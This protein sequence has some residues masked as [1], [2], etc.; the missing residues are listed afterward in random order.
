MQVYFLKLKQL[1]ISFTSIKAREVSLVAA[2]CIFALL[3][4]LH[5]PLV[6]IHAGLDPSFNYGIGKA[7]LRNESFGSDFIATYGPLGYLIIDYLPNF[8]IQASLLL[9]FFALAL[10]LGSYLFVRAWGPKYW[11]A[12]LGLGLGVIY[13]FSLSYGIEWNLLT[14]FLLY[15]FL[16]AYS[17]RRS[18]ALLAVLSL[19]AATFLFIKLTLGLAAL[20]SAMLLPVSSAVLARSAR[21]RTLLAE[22]FTVAL[23]YVVGVLVWSRLLHV[24]NLIMYARTGWEMSTGFSEAMSYQLPGTFVATVFCAIALLALVTVYVVDFSR[25]KIE[26]RAVFIIPALYMIWKYAVVRQDYHILRL[27]QII[28]PL[29]MIIIVYRLHKTKT[30]AKVITLAMASLVV[31]LTIYTVPLNRLDLAKDFLPVLKIPLVNIQNGS[32]LHFFEVGSEEQAWQKAS[33]TNVASDKLPDKFVKRIGASGVDIYPWE[34][35]IVAANNLT[36]QNRPSPYSFETYRPLF[37]NLNAAYFESARAPKYV[38]WHNEGGV[39]GVDARN[40]VWDEPKTLRTMLQFYSPVES[41]DQ[42]ILLQRNKHAVQRSAS[43]L[44]RQIVDWGEWVDVPTPTQQKL[45]FFTASYA[46]GKTIAIEDVLLRSESVSVSLEYKDES[47]VTY[48]VVPKMLVQGY[49]ASDVPM[50]WDEL[51]KLLSGQYSHSVQRIRFNAN[52][53]Y[54]YHTG[55]ISIKWFASSE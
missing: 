45:T 48:R 42:F 29:L 26:P 30:T 32:F 21:K 4:T 5:Q 33:R 25:L 12:Q 43:T 36:W 54:V 37:D 11:A 2:F 15:S 14:V 40:V 44:G 38:I 28:L 39:Y 1:V 24:T 6:P 9:V 47:I 50:T 49:L 3:C 13:V 17:T 20:G 31:A 52:R 34:V 22:V 55:K 27:A 19:V 46:V 41:N 35:A 51:L 8:V 7:V 18:K 10:G 16:Y 23:P 53:G